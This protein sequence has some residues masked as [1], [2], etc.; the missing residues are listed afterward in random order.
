MPQPVSIVLADDHPLLL[1]GLSDLVSSEDGFM[2]AGTA[3]DGPAALSLIELARPDIAV[4][5]LSMPGISGLGVLKEIARGHGGVKTV[6]LTAMISDDEIVEAM[7]ANV[8][9]ILLK[10]SAPEALIDCLREVAGGR[11]WL[12]AELVHPALSRR[13]KRDED[14]TALQMLTPRERQIADL[15]CEG[16]S[17]KEI[18]GMIGMSAGTV[19]IHLHN[20][21]VKLQVGNRTA[22]AAMMLN[23]RA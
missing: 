17:N 7:A 14:G 9:G 18:A 20:I 22:L 23:N 19:R 15:V 10:E 21:Y 3:S 12:P 11:K 16:R 5:D 2:V 6:F 1:K 8:W 4:L 13:A